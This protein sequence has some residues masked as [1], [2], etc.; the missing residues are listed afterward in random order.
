M[1]IRGLFFG[2]YEVDSELIDSSAEGSQSF[3]YEELHLSD[4]TIEQ[5]KNGKDLEVYVQGENGET[6]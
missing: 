4:E 2:D 1:N 6:E 3:G 5:L